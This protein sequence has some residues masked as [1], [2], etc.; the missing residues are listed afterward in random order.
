MQTSS[1]WSSYD[2][3]VHFTLKISQLPL[4]Y[5]DKYTL[6]KKPTSARV[7]TYKHCIPGALH[8]TFRSL[9]SSE[10]IL[11]LEIDASFLVFSHILHLKC[12]FSFLLFPQTPP[13]SHFLPPFSSGQMDLNHYKIG[14]VLYLDQ[15]SVSLDN[16]WHLLQFFFY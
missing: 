13:S 6:N 2:L 16:S 5:A 1:H 11:N 12:S 4:T 7:T 15:N 10:N 3:Q 14:D 8:M 9:S